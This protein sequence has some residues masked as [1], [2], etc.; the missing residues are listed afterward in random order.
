MRLTADWLEAEPTQRVF[1]AL[2]GGGHRA[3]AVG[4]CVRNALLGAPVS[5]IDIAT[6]A[7]PE[8][9]VELARAAGLKPVPTGIEHGT[10]T[11]VA[12]GVPHEV[13]TFRRDVETDGR[14]ATVA[15]SDD[16]AEDAGRRDFTVN[17]LYA[18]AD[19]TVVDPLGGLPDLRAR[20][21]RFIGDPEARIR[22]DY[23]RILRFFRFTAWYGD[24]ALG[25]NAEGLAACAAHGEGLD[26]LSRERIGHEMRRLLAA[27]DPAPCVAAMARTGLLARVLPGADDR[28]LAPLVH[29][30]GDRAPDWLRRLAVLGGDASGLRLSNVEARALEALREA[31]GRPFALGHALGVRGEDAVLIRAASLGQPVAPG[32]LEE[33]RAGAAAT[34]PLRAKDLMP[35]LEGPALGEALARAKAAWVASAGAL[36]RDALLEVAREG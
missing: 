7:P 27:P 5:D 19:G 35:G 33:A 20:H 4:G 21:V 6:D 14:R 12:A 13:T 24:P 36:G 25:L 2:A 1:A 16:V 31:D 15:F 11:V 32:A 26:R 3:L 22:E 28:A 18:E 9:V 17:A 30:E 29:L 8:R 34:F 10:V 23:L